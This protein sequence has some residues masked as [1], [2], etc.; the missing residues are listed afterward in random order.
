M[1]VWGKS[2]AAQ[3]LV[4]SL[5]GECFLSYCLPLQSSINLEC[6]RKAVHCPW[7]TLTCNWQLVLNLCHRFNL[8]TRYR[9]RR[10]SVLKTKSWLKISWSC[11]IRLEVESS[12]STVRY[13]RD[14]TCCVLHRLE[15]MKW[16]DSGG[17][18][19]CSIAVRSGVCVCV[20]V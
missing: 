7:N 13:V 8:S 19:Y 14:T 17:V 20:C 10:M 5:V 16:E 6:K 4:R 2:R 1:D 15:G 9:T 12:S 3:Q 11:V 18:N